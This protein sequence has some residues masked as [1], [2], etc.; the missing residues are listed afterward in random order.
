M[1]CNELQSDPQTLSVFGLKKN[2]TLNNLQFFHVSHY[3]SLDIM[4]DI[5]EGV[6]QFEMKLLFEFL[7]ENLFVKI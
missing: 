3:Y 4:H 5:L 6:A 7:S 2:S 1:H